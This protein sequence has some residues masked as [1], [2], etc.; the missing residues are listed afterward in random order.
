MGDM[1]MNTADSRS[2]LYKLPSG[3]MLYLFNNT[4]DRSRACI[5]AALSEDG[6]KTFPYV[7]LLD[8]RVGSSYAHCDVTAEGDI[9]VVYDQGRSR[10]DKTSGSEILFARIT[11]KDIIKGELVSPRSCIKRLV[12]RYG[13][14]PR[15]DSF[16]AILD[17][18]PPEVAEEYKDRLS[19]EDY[20]ELCRKFDKN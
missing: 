20:V 4:R 1:V 6:G 15:E 16:K 5:S 10:A 9:F 8:E 13:L 7:L 3:R 2:Y 14:A 19:L 11:E 18:L 17:R 12:T